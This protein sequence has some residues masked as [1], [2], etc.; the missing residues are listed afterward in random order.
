MGSPPDL[1]VRRLH[2][3]LSARAYLRAALYDVRVGKLYL[4]SRRDS[5][6][7]EL[8][9]EVEELLEALVVLLALP[10]AVERGVEGLANL[11][12]FESAAEL[13]V[14]PPYL[15]DLLD[16]PAGVAAGVGPAAHHGHRVGHQWTICT[17][18][19]SLPFVA[20]IIPGPFPNIRPA[21]LF[22][23]N[24]ISSIPL[25]FTDPLKRS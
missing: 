14:L 20:T 24:N 6:L 10:E 3:L 5:R 9:T 22:I 16:E 12:E 2:Q 7:A 8:L 1:D 25:S 23:S 11:R 13:V 21:S 4:D 19:D 15:G 17:G 18:L